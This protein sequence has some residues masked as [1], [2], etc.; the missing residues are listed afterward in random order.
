MMSRFFC[1]FLSLVSQSIA[2]QP[3]HQ[4]ND[5]HPKITYQTCTKTAGCASKAGAVSM[6]A[7]WAWSHKVGTYTNC[8][9][10]S[11]WDKNLCPDPVSCAK[12]CALDTGSV[13]E[14]ASTYGVSTTD[15]ALQLDFVTKQQYGTNVG[16]RT[17]LFDDSS[18][19]YVMFKLKN[20]ATEG[21]I[22]YPFR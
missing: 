3:G 16:S 14:Y 10:G 8:Y 22:P 5:A 13:S 21:R 6:D 19:Q 12:N 9:T 20:K 2:Q 7:N 18:E 17:Y 4:K 15:D 1:L 11:A